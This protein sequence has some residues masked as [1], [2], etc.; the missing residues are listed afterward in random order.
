MFCCFFLGAI[1]PEE[2]LSHFIRTDGFRF[3]EE[4]DVREYADSE[5][6]NGWERLEQHQ[7]NSHEER[8]KENARVHAAAID[9]PCPQ[10]V[11]P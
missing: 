5:E 8:G 11:P 2:N 10:G 7:K 1:S 6:K 4:E 3:P 9:C